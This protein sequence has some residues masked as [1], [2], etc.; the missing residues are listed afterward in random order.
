[1]INQAE[2][3]AEVQLGVLLAILFVI[4]VSPLLIWSGVN[5]VLF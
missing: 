1:V 4:I 3:F 5:E 2:K